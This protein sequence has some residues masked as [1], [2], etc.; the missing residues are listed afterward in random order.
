MNDKENEEVDSLFANRQENEHLELQLAS[1][2]SILQR[3]N[4]SLFAFN[5]KPGDIFQGKSKENNQEERKCPRI[6]SLVLGKIVTRNGRWTSEDPMKKCSITGYEI[7][8]RSQVEFND[9]CMSLAG[10][11]AYITFKFAKVSKYLGTHPFAK[12]TFKLEC[13]GEVDDCVV[14][15]NVNG[16]SVNKFLDMAHIKSKENGVT[17]LSVSGK[18]KNECK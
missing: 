13:F 12:V 3:R 11:G 14:E 7:S 6:Q 1:K 10:K 8:D 4:T 15:L 17:T 16:A 2:S 5:N 9:D 18:M